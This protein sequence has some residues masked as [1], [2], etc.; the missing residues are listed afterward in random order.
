M[1]P[2]QV[3]KCLVLTILV[4]LL[5]V[6]LFRS[7]LK[8]S[9]R[10]TSFQKTTINQETILYPS[11]SICRKYTFD[12]YIDEDLL[13]PTVTLSKKQDLIRNNSW[14]RER[15]IFFLGHSGML[16]LTYP[17]LTTMGGTD[18]AKLCSFPSPNYFSSPCDFDQ[19]QKKV[20]YTRMTDNGTK[21]FSKRG[22]Q[23]WGYCPKDC[24][25]E[26]A[27]WSSPFNLASRD[28]MWEG[29]LFDLRSWDV[30]ICHTYNPPEP[31][32][33]DLTSRLALLLGSVT[34]PGSY[35]LDSFQVY[36]HEKGQFWPRADLFP[37]LSVLN[38]TEMEASF[39]ISKVRGLG[40]RQ[41]CTMADEEYSLTSCIMDYVLQQ[42]GCLFQVQANTLT[43]NRSEDV[44]K[45]FHTLVWAKTASVD[46]LYQRTKCLPKCSCTEYQVR[47]G[48]F[49]VSDRQ[50]I[51]DPTK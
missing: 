12:N 9:K 8:Y 11:V 45:Y 2:F 14:L 46:E 37:M 41:P 17:C 47:K 25:G 7:G 27:N 42:T 33:A 32:D 34:S 6:T 38:G 21:Y 19:S 31:S 3:F 35:W 15:A 1:N 10:N 29:G 20:C 23:K 28:N 22:E 24:H 40:L 4:L 16:G 49:I 44:S 48:S 43:C 39:K 30:G 5:C 36:L 26:K 50:I 13:N 18:S 51:L